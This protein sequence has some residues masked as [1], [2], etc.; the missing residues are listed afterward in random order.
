M[1][2]FFNV[3]DSFFFL[4]CSCF[5]WQ[6]IVWTQSYRPFDHNSCWSPLQLCFI[7]GLGSW[8]FNVN[9]IILCYTSKLKL[10][11]GGKLVNGGD[12]L[13]LFVY[14]HSNK[15]LWFVSLIENQSCLSCFKQIMDNVVGILIQSSWWMLTT[16]S[17]PLPCVALRTFCWGFYR[18]WVDVI[19]RFMLLL[20]ETKPKTTNPTP[21]FFLLEKNPRH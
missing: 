7:P 8:I 6:E 4:P 19:W 5:I 12:W 3:E 15:Q 16:I 21:L 18:I 17:R 11:C 14:L 13:F 10:N 20:E 2:T 1:N 9:F